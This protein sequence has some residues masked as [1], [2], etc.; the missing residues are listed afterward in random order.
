MR[1]A[2]AN[3]ASV[4]ALSPAS[5]VK[6]SLPGLSSHTA[7]APGAAAAS[8]ETTARQR[9]VLDREQ[10]GRVLRLVQRLRDD[11]RDRLA[12]ITHPLLRQ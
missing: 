8:A 3:A 10:L 1:A 4:A 9:L 7:G 6:A 5:T 2:R 12:D 11:E